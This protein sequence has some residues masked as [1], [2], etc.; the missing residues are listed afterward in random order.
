MSL[1]LLVK[2]LDVLLKVVGIVAGLKTLL[3]SQIQKKTRKDRK[4]HR[5]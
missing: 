2:I 3:G 4:N 1:D 5:E